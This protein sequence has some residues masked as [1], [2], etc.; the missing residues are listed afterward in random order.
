MR[1]FPAIAWSRNGRETHSPQKSRFTQRA[2]AR[3]RRD[4]VILRRA[5]LG[6]ALAMGVY[7]LVAGI[8]APRY[9]ERTLPA[10]LEQRTGMSA[11]VG[12]IAFNPFLLAL[13][14]RDVALGPEDRPVLGF[15]AL[16]ID[17]QLIQTL[18]RRAWTLDAIR[19]DRPQ[20]NA[21]VDAEGRLNLAT[22]ATKLS[23]AP[24][25][26]PAEPKQ[27]GDPPRLLVSHVQIN[28]GLLSFLD[29]SGPQPVG[30]RLYPLELELE[31]L[32]T[33]PDH[34]GRY[35]LSGRLPDGA[36]LL[37]RGDL[38]LQPLHSSGQLEFK[39]LRLATL[40][41]FAQDRLRIEA[42]EGVVDTTARYVFTAPPGKQPVFVLE[43]V[44]M[45]GNGLRLT[46]AG[47][48]TPM[49]VLQ[50]MTASGGRFDLASRSMKLER[51]DMRGGQ[52]LVSADQEGGLN[53]TRIGKSTAPATPVAG[54]QASQP[55]HFSIGQAALSGVAV[56]YVDHSRKSTPTVLLHDV[57]GRLGLDVG[58]GGAT[59]VSVS[60]IAMRAG[61]I[62]LS[63]PNIPQP[64]LRI[65]SLQLAGGD[66]D[67]ASKRITA[68][69]I[70]LDGG[71]LALAPGGE[72]GIALASAFTPRVPAEKKAESGW[73]YALKSLDLR[74]MEV[75]PGSPAAEWFAANRLHLT[76]LS[77][78]NLVQGG[79][80]PASFS[81]SIRAAQGGTVHATGTASQ[82][83]SNAD[84]NVELSA[85]SLK[86]LQPIAARY[87]AVTVRSGEAAASARIAYREGAKPTIEVR[88]SAALRDVLLA[89]ATTGDRLLSW[90]SMTA[91]DIRVETAPNLLAIHEIVVRGAGAKIEIS[92]D[93][94]FNLARI[95]KPRAEQVGE[96]I[97]Q[98]AEHAAR[99][100]QERMPVTIARLRL[101]GADIDFA[102]YSLV[103][104][105]STSIWQFNG[106]AVDITTRNEPRAALEFKG[107]IGE[108]GSA[109]VDGNL[110]AFDP[111][112]F[113][114]I[115]VDLRNVAM[116]PLTPYSA[117]FLGRRIKSGDLWV[118]LNYR[119][120]NSEMRGENEVTLQNFTLGERVSEG[121]LLNLPLDLAIA[122]LT[123]DQGR[124]T[125]DIPVSGDVT[126]PK[127]ELRD[128]IFDAIK[129]LLAGVVTA[130]FRALGRLFG[131]DAERLESVQF[132]PGQ[133][134]LSPPE[135]EKLV[136][137]AN[138]LRQ[139]P[140]LRL[141]VR[142]GYDPA[143]DGVALRTMAVRREVSRELGIRLLPGEEPG[144]VA[145]SD[146]HT[147][148]V[149][150]KLLEQR[151]GRGAVREFATWYARST[152]RQPKR[153]GALNALTGRASPDV[154]FYEALY[155]HL[156]DIYPLPLSRGERLAVQR[157]QSI[158]QYL[159][160]RGVES[161][162]VF[163]LTEREDRRE[164]E[165]TAELELD[166]ISGDGKRA[167]TAQNADRPRTSAEPVNAA[168]GR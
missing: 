45:T 85:L 26:A 125:A 39:G 131:D 123:D 133:A 110:F 120:E 73:K 59:R 2:P 7:V 22:L 33:L 93:R 63:V 138:L 136:A 68:G 60:K 21:V 32:A 30:T 99:T 166:S 4:L 105:F 55:W 119:I 142:A 65:D 67:T 134:A 108:F 94:Q 49:L 48:G 91:E 53:W 64:L 160:A 141:I 72:Q 90:R 149:L 137:V 165:I 9:L 159:R 104:P 80:K 11:S 107:R 127:F 130:P 61:A 157:A 121:N 111:K 98:A 1:T 41:K 143:R 52:V 112:L 28:R 17:F 101:E 40:W 139:R 29:R 25:T 164:G 144:P 78:R 56:R 10:Y 103:F 95:M 163:H 27:A 83:F 167:K 106:A 132:E 156:I 31:D 114:D 14:A 148:R 5:L 87:A 100:E 47:T 168:A 117:T 86:P 146:V 69:R 70:A 140:Q 50:R 153:L 54:K 116:P 37:W 154:K 38:Q 71:R 89:D 135:R 6:M 76:A 46:E 145:F 158:M 34:E 155:R 152:G 128:A 75:F 79:R 24:R 66:I 62:A 97:E 58:L 35:A 12:S 129:G 44:Q 81:A 57:S 115:R 88:G 36:S 122:L 150:E 23:A 13:E 109:E 147:Q 151:S 3:R 113:T 82:D 77:I 15:D 92:R 162:R 19:M 124:I 8:L 102:D 96:K 16:V 43:D 20:I 161:G 74:S 51:V 18:L 84:A 126:N 118:K 42:P